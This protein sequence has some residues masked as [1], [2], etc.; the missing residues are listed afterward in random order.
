[1]GA[2]IPHTKNDIVELR[3]YKLEHGKRD[4]FI[5]L[6]EKYFIESQEELGMRLAGQFRDMDDQNRFTWI[7]TFPNMIDREASLKAFY[8]GP[9]WQKHRDS[10]NPMLFDNDNVLLL[11]P[12]WPD[13]GFEIRQRQPAACQGKP[14]FATIHYL[15]K[16]PAEGFSSYF[17][18]VVEPKM[19]E[20]GL[21]LLGAYVTEHGENTF[22]RLPVRQAE[23]VFVVFTQAT[24]QDAYSAKWKRI[25]SAIGTQL[26]DY[27]ERT[28]QLLRLAPTD[29]STIC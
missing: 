22:P 13:S 8:S 6:F 2:E 21:P 19:R 26:A 9:V 15:W 16:D 10:A 4:E 1:M 17:K 29:R 20:V 23:K 12:A 25:L 11:K 18:N 3:Q 28:P 14:S 7:R 24:N 27:E 5:S